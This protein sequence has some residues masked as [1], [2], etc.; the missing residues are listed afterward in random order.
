[1][2]HMPYRREYYVGEEAYQIKGV[3]KLSYPL[4]DLDGVDINGIEKILHFSYYTNL[5]VDPSELPTIFL[6]NP[7]WPKNLMEKMLTL[8]FEI[9]SVQSLFFLDF[10]Q[11]LLIEKQQP[12]AI[13]IDSQYNYTSIQFYHNYH[14]QA[15]LSL[16]IAQG[17][18]LFLTYFRRLYQSRGNQL[19]LDNEIQKDILIKFADFARPIQNQPVTLIDY[20]LP[21]G[22]IIKIGSERSQIF[23][24]L[25]DPL[26]AGTEDKSIKHYLQNFAINVLHNFPLV[27]NYSIFWGGE[28][29]QYQ[30]FQQR[31]QT[32]LLPKEWVNKS[33]EVFNHREIY[34]QISALDP[35]NPLII[36]KYIL[37][38]EYEMDGPEILISHI[39]DEYSR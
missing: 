2:E 37:K 12:H 3:L 21:D 29:T 18:S 14:L 28:I 20:L 1:M 24:L 11:M 23:D 33:F 6:F 30:N 25:L 13:I 19:S 39:G 38:N 31:I 8:F 9:F 15:K 34:E 35:Q 10:Y 16:K 26:M 4:M 17:T 5:R 36:Q 32:D 22:Q 27:E 7:I